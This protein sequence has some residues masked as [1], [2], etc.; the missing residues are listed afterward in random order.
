MDHMSCPFV[1]INDADFSFI[2]GSGQKNETNNSLM[3]ILITLLLQTSGCSVS[4]NRDSVRRTAAPHAVF[5]SPNM[6]TVLVSCVLQHILN[7][8]QS[9]RAVMTSLQHI[10]KS[11]N[12]EISAST[13]S[14]IFI[15]T[16][17]QG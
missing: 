3:R 10:L 1:T 9:I 11:Q 16:L 15:K 4:L 5:K 7:V 13:Q 14:Q 6:Q 17:C 2:Q 12:T 8:M